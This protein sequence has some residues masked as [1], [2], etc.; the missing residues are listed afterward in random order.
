M[1]KH[2]KNAPTNRIQSVY[3]PGGE[4]QGETFENLQLEVTDERDIFFSSRKNSRGTKEN[5]EWSF[6][7]R[8][9]GRVESKKVGRGV[10]VR[11]QRGKFRA[12]DQSYAREGRSVR[13]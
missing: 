6:G 10:S 2:V 11:R 7:S 5:P 9:S 13:V 3:V 8:G 4:G 1:N 12:R